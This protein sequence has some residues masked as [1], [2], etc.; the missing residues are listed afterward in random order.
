MPMFEGSDFLKSVDISHFADVC[1][2]IASVPWKPKNEFSRYGIDGAN[3]V[4]DFWGVQPPDGDCV[5]T[6]AS[7]CT[8]TSSGSS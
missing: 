8:W 3:S 6:T 5:L 7:Y 4:S 2:D 1:T